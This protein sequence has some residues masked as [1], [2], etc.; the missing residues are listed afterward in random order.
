MY[1]Q[2]CMPEVE[3]LMSR[4]SMDHLTEDVEVAGVRAIMLAQ[5]MH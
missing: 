2:I 5:A 3:F 1:R 4:E